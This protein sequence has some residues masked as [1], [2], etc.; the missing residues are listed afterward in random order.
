MRASAEQRLRLLTRGC[1]QPS[2]S[3]WRPIHGRPTRSI[4]WRLATGR[5]ARPYNG[6]PAASQA[7]RSGAFGRDRARRRS[8]MS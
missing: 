7:S 2:Q 8:H 3:V 5:A 1:Q 6:C 4:S